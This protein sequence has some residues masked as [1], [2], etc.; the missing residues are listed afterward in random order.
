MT[1]QF[2]N[3]GQLLKHSTAINWGEGSF[4]PGRT[5][6]APAKPPHIQP[7]DTQSLSS[8]LFK[9]NA[10]LQNVQPSGPT[11]TLALLRAERLV[12]DLQ[13]ELTHAKHGAANQTRIQT[14]FAELRQELNILHIAL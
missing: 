2:G 5:V 13:R 10:A 8:Q 1:Y 9:I 7:V 14:L 11:I 3:P 4:I 12:A 6:L